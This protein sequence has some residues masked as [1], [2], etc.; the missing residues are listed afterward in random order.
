V[1]SRRRLL[2]LAGAAASV[3]ASSSIALARSDAFIEFV[4]RTATAPLLGG[5]GGPV[6]VWTFNGTVPGPTIRASKGDEIRIR[7]RNDLDQPTSIHWH[8]IRIDNRMDG[9]AG[10]TQDAVNPGETFDYVFEVPDA[11]TFWYHSHNRS[12]EQVERGLYG[13][14]DRRRN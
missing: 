9:V 13:G 3:G 1:I 10:L 5:D 2:Q 6:P 14:A 11:G 12:W 4:A 8:G 7:F